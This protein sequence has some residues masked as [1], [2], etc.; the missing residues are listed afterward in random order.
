MPEEA[1]V[2]GNCGSTTNFSAPVSVILIFAPGLERPFPLIPGDDYQVCTRCDAVRTLIDR[3]A[4][5]NPTTAAAGRW[6]RAVVLFSDGS[7]LDV[8][9]LN[10]PV[11]PTQKGA[12]A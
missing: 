6:T 10:E 12:L 3:A 1:P 7:G 9:G 2:C 11:K 8:S 5:S 4:S